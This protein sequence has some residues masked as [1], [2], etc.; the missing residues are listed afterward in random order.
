[1]TWQDDLSFQFG[2]AGDSG[3]EV[4]DFKPQQY[5]VAIRLV[6]RIT[7]LPMVVLDLKAVQLEDQHTCRDQSLIFRPAVRA[8]TTEET[9]VPPAARFDIGHR[10]QG[11]GTH[12]HLHRNYFKSVFRPA[13]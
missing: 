6:F 12:E 3:I 9:L 2:G 8:L 1:M 5:A 13:V 11:L 7:D 10:D 4:V